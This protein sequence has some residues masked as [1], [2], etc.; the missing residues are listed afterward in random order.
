VALR[1]SAD[2]RSD[3][4][5]LGYACR[6]GQPLASI[7]PGA[8]AVVREPVVCTPADTSVFMAA[9]IVGES[10]SGAVV[11][12]HAKADLVGADTPSGRAAVATALAKAAAVVVRTGSGTAVGAWVESSLPSI[13]ANGAVKDQVEGYALKVGRTSDGGY[14]LFISIAAA[15]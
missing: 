11:E 14:Q 1:S 4:E 6:A 15:H 12:V 13:E 5:Q 8:S 9:V 3:L 2:I 10:A 7:L